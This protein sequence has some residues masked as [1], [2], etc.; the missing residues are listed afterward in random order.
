VASNP[1][2]AAPGLFAVQVGAF[3]DRANA[4]RLRS[5]ME[6]RYGLARLLQRADPTI[7]RLPVGAYASE[8]RANLLAACI[9]QD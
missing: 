8:D 5:Q 4:E 6:A 9:R 2:P 1:W 7:W 3:R